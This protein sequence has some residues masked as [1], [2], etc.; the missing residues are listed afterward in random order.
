MKFGNIRIDSQP[1]ISEAACNKC[2]HY[3]DVVSN[4]FLDNLLFCSKCE[5]V[6]ELKLIKMPNKFITEEYLE[7]CRKRTSK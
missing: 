4:G 5:I 6:Y 2:G 7:Q 1:I 3:C